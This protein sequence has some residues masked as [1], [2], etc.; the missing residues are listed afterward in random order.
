MAGR[1]AGPDGVNLISGAINAQLDTKDWLRQSVS[2]VVPYEPKTL[3]ERLSV[4]QG[5]F[6]VPVNVDA[7]FMQNLAALGDLRNVVIK[8]VVP[9]GVRPR[10]LQQLRLMNITRASLFPGLDGF[11]QS[12]RQF[13]VEPE[14]I[15]DEPAVVPQTRE[16]RR[17]LGDVRR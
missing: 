10:A 12:F 3:S 2:S 9:V 4:Q 17:A 11:A 8:F 15:F 5:A 16:R 6:I 1:G 14:M 13:L 7:S